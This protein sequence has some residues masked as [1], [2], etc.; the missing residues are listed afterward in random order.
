MIKELVVLFLIALVAGSIWNGMNEA[1]QSGGTAQS[2]NTQQ[3]GPQFQEVADVGSDTFQG[4]VLDSKEPVLVEFYTTGCVAC[5][6]MAPVLAQLSAENENKFHVYRLNCDKNSTLSDR[7]Y[8]GPV[9][10][11]VL[12]DKGRLVN[13]TIGAQSKEELL[14]WIQNNLGTPHGVPI[15]IPT[16]TEQ[17]G[18]LPQG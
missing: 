14:G 10:A 18:S 13:Q 7:Y 5:Q 11:F 15:T 3:A 2:G 4:L 1:P 6:K 8:S 9:P 12:F 17:Q 16:S